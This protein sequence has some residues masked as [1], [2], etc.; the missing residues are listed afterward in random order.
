MSS[1][2]DPGD[3]NSFFYFTANAVKGRNSGLEWEQTVRLLPQVELFGSV[4]LLAT[5]IDTYTFPTEDGEVTL[6]DRAAAHAPNYT[7]SVGGEYRHQSGLGARL[8]LIGMDQ[9]FYSDGHDQVSEPYR[10]VNAHIAY[11]WEAWSVQV[12]GRNLLD[13]RYGVRGFYFGLEPP[14]YADKLYKTYGDPRQVGVRLTTQFSSL[15]N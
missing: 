12:W 3:P 1:Q 5:H 8:A 2:Q 9:F 13:E 6:G 10:L 15:G 4:G 14:D 7:F 11:Q